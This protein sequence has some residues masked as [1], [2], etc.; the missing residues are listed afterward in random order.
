MRVHRD[1]S[2]LRRA[3]G[4]D[5]VHD[6]VSIHV[7]SE[8][9]IFAAPIVGLGIT[10][11][12]ERT[13]A[14][15]QDHQ[16]STRHLLG[17]A[18]LFGFHV[19]CDVVTPVLV[20]I[21]DLHA[22][23]LVLGE[24]CDAAGL[25]CAVATA[26][27]EGYLPCCGLILLIFLPS[28]RHEVQLAVSVEVP[29]R[30]LIMA[31]GEREGG[32]L[33]GAVR[34]L[35]QQGDAGFH[36]RNR[37]FPSFH[38]D[39]HPSVAVEV[40]GHDCREAVVI[41]Q[42]ELLARLQFFCT[43]FIRFHGAVTDVSAS[44]VVADPLPVEPA[45]RY[46]RF[47]TRA[48]RRH[49]LTHI[50]GIGFLRETIAAA[51]FALVDEDAINLSFLIFI[52]MQDRCT[53]HVVQRFPSGFGNACADGAD[54]TL[55]IET[56]HLSDFSFAL[57]DDFVTAVRGPTGQTTLGGSIAEPPHS[58]ITLL[59]AVVIHLSITTENGGF[60]AG[61]RA[62]RFTEFE[63]L[64]TG[65]HVAVVSRTATGIALRGGA[66]TTVFFTHHADGAEVALLTRIYFSVAALTTCAAGII[67]IGTV[68][69]R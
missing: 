14:L 26:E 62:A 34:V 19:D 51:E 61:V 21:R 43:I 31:V 3:G 48:E 13:A 58:R 56:V 28:C 44:D 66:G 30:H 60:R 17:S 9:H 63:E 45:G 7:G 46:R 41:R 57:V 37:V 39:I 38:D 59:I 8:S 53:F 27:V 22:V 16:C 40:P 2:V 36:S 65:I 29:F 68:G 23:R 15:R 18:R 69:A 12:E 1:C 49:G 32:R 64:I 33:K 67:Q 52:R 42:R 4:R 25:E 24:R 10:E 20:E 47:G 55:F 11:C 50:T 35:L 6:A 54:V 5:Q